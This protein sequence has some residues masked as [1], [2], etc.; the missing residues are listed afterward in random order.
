MYQD[1]TYA[2]F[3]IFDSVELKE[4]LGDGG[5]GERFLLPNVLIFHIACD[6]SKRVGK[7]FRK[8]R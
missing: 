2:Y 3:D 1:D 4:Y 8:V 6:I 5:Y 7:S